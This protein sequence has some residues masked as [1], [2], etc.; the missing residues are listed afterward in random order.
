MAY[1]G[2]QIQGLLNKLPRSLCANGEVT[3]IV[4]ADGD[5]YLSGLIGQR[6]Q[7]RFRKV[8]L[9]TDFLDH[10][11]DVA[12]SDDR[13][14]ILNGE[15]QVY[16]LDYTVRTCDDG[17]VTEIYTPTCCRGFAERAVAI[18][19][20]AHHV[21]ILTEKGR[22]FGA[23]SNSEYQLV[24]QGDCSYPTAVEILVTD[25]VLHDNECCD[26]FH[27][28]LVLVDEPRRPK[29]ECQT[30][31]CLSGRIKS[32][33]IDV[34]RTPRCDDPYA[35]SSTSIGGLLVTTGTITAA[36]IEAVLPNDNIISYFG[37]YCV[38]GD[39]A[40]GTV[41]FTLESSYISPGKKKMAAA[42]LAPATPE[43]FDVSVST[44]IPL[45]AEPLP[46]SSQ[47]FDIR[48]GDCGENLP[49][50]ASLL[51]GGGGPVPRS[52]PVT[53]GTPALVG[54]PA[55]TLSVTITP[56]LPTGLTSY[57]PATLL[58]T[59]SSE[60]DPI[61][62]L[63]FA[64]AATIELAVS[65]PTIVSCIK[66]PCCKEECV[67]KC[68]PCF[69]QPC[70]TRIGA[71]GDVTVLV[72]ECNQLWALGSLYKIRNN[73]NLLRRDG[74]EE[75][76][77]KYDTRIA[78]PSDQLECMNPVINNNCNCRGK[79]ECIPGSKF[80]IS[81]FGV[82]VSIPAATPSDCGDACGN[83]TFTA[84]DFIRTLRRIDETPNCNNTCVPCSE[85]VTVYFECGCRD[86]FVPDTVTIYNR[87]SI[88]KALNK[89]FKERVFDVDINDDNVV[90]FTLN[91]YCVNG[92]R[93][94]ID[95]II[96]LDF[97]RRDCGDDDR[98]RDCRNLDIFVDIDLDH[99]NRNIVF[100]TKRP[101]RITVD[102]PV[103]CSDRIQ[104]ILNY[105]DVMSPLNLERVRHLYTD[106]PLTCKVFTNPPPFRLIDVYAQ[107][108]DH[109]RLLRGREPR[110]CRDRR[111][112]DRR[113]RD[114]GRNLI[115]VTA[116]LPV[117]F[118]LGQK[119]LD[120]AVGNNNIS[121]LT[122]N[123]R[124]RNEVFAI[125]QNCWG[126]LGTGDFVTRTCFQRTETC[127]MD[128]AVSRIFAGPHSTFYV[129]LDSAVYAAGDYPG[130]VKC[131]IPKRID[132]IRRSWETRTLAV[133]I[134]TVVL[135]GGNGNVYGYGENQL[136][137][138]GLGHTSRVCD[139]YLISWC[140]IEDREDDCKRP[141]RKCVEGCYKEDCDARGT[142][143]R[144]SGRDSGRVDDQLLG[145][146]ERYARTEGAGRQ[147]REI[148]VVDGRR[149]NGCAPRIVKEECCSRP[150][151]QVYVSYDRG[152]GGF[153][154]C[155][156]PVC[157]CERRE[158]GNSRIT[159]RCDDNYIFPPQL[160]RGP[161][162]PGVA[163]RAVQFSQKRYTNAAYQGQIFVNWEGSGN[164][165]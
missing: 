135:L 20:G 8:R 44:A 64:T 11:V 165:W 115:A 58:A 138:L 40:R 80:D 72:S 28:N 42:T 88:C 29:Q 139:F 37:T 47:P 60:T 147:V 53:L 141:L 123:L 69:P 45:I 126:E 97:G 55:T 140:R 148:A 105:G 142:C 159:R 41:T 22:V 89:E 61:T 154:G 132:L 145:R 57:T 124:C 38:C 118:T 112:G 21:V 134:N 36:P 160:P 15:G 107:G 153:C 27:G 131:A 161:K 65:A 158:P 35:N 46:G 2:K 125:G 62:T 66:V 155:E 144:D 19:A 83:G 43:T 31:K 67:E 101:K 104:T 63:A 102:M 111:D 56:T 151:P 12:C 74:L 82:S 59:F 33:C 5:L 3:A 94:C 87:I 143:G 49:I 24:P 163:S 133:T 9:N 162:Y 122:G 120:V 81:K 98:D 26:N 48:C 116:D 84:C 77:S 119:I 103:F 136:G 85:T 70:W 54:S 13:V 149:G 157:G 50:P 137:Q 108:G 129:T 7:D 164:V 78:F 109:V 34:C 16:A 17:V 121:V 150:K 99:G 76:L 51:S 25:Y 30:V 39:R 106:S 75:L 4:T 91:T 95:D 128:C 71:G 93:V 52:I 10:V 152:R 32:R 127:Y 1:S 114:T 6:I 68:V 130:L 146:G 100:T 73:L 96:V 110:D 90:D 156:K 79:C 18:K 14:Y 117:V 113:D 23:G 92:T 86:A